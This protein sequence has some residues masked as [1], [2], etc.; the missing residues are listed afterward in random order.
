MC[1]LGLRVYRVVCA[2]RTCDRAKGEYVMIETMDAPTV[3]AETSPSQYKLDKLFDKVLVAAQPSAVFSSPVV[4][5]AYTVITASEVMAG[6]GLGFG[7]G[8]GPV[9]TAQ[10]NGKAATREVAQGS[11]GGGGGGSH[12]RP[13]AAILI[14]PDGVKVQPI[15]DA[16]KIALAAMAAWGSVALLAIRLARRRS[17]GKP[18]SK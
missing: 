1:C 12:G 10:A 6:G 13:I 5:G 15:V 7:T 8:T 18:R 14:G 11:G 4:S 2:S 17:P 16:T 9:T 3:P